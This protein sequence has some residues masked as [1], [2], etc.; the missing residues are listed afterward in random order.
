MVYLEI[1]TRAPTDRFH[2]SDIDLMGDKSESGV[3]FVRKNGEAI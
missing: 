2:Y 1:G 3:R